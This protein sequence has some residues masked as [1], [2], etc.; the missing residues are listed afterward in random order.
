MTQETGNKGR[1]VL[2]SFR[3]FEQNISLQAPHKLN[4]QVYGLFGAHEVGKKRG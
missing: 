2:S 1:R 4:I 3:I